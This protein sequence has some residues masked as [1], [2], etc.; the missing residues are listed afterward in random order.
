MAGV[1]KKI[2]LIDD[3]RD[4]AL[5]SGL[6]QDGYEV[7]VCDSAQKA[8]ALVFPFR[9]QLIVVHLHQLSRKDTLTLQECRALADGVPIV[10]ATSVAG[11]ESI[12]FAL[13][14]GA[15]SFLSLP[16]NPEAIRRVLDG[17][18]PGS[19]PI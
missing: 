12:R 19:G 11:Q 13:E 15:T 3:E 7:I 4:A 9:P 8:W 6:H 1:R 18:S 2:V 14:E 17:L 10:V 5:F 16:A